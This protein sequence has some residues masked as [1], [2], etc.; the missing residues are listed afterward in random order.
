M[1]FNGLNLQISFYMGQKKTFGF[2]YYLFLFPLFD[3]FDAYF[4]L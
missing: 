2:G 3:I 4:I 1:R